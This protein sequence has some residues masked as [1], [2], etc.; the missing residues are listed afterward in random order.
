MLAGELYDLG[1]PQLLLAD[2]ERPGAVLPQCV[3]KPP[4]TSVI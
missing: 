1:Y 2:R 4:F 3:G